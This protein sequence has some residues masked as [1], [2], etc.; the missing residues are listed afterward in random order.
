[1]N[2][3]NNMRISTAKSLLRFSDASIESIAEQCGFSDSAY[4]IK[5]FK[6][7]E[8]ITPYSYRKKW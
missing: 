2:D 1:M 7:A 6:N 5:V 8:N 3:L 4:F